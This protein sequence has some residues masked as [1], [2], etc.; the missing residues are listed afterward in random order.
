GMTSI[1]Q[2]SNGSVF[3]NYGTFIAIG[4]S[5]Y[6]DGGKGATPSFVNEGRFTTAANSQ[7][8]GFSVPFNS[9]GGS[10][11]IKHDS[12]L[13]FDAGG[14]ST[15]ATF[16]LETNATFYVASAYHFD[17]LTTLSGEG[18]FVYDGSGTEVL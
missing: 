2:A 8:V 5:S 7:V 4:F 12:W 17:Q 9:P 14:E 1:L 10:I 3:N 18:G 11:D 13:E 15:G 6:T 16:E